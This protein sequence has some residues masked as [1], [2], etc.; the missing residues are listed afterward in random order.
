ML[1]RNKTKTIISRIQWDRS[2]ADQKRTQIEKG[3]HI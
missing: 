2:H 3:F 1:D